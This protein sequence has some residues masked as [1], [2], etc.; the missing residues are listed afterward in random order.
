MSHPPY[1]NSRS[2]LVTGDPIPNEEVMRMC[3]WSPD[4][5]REAQDLG[6]S[7]Q[8]SPTQFEALLFYLKIENAHEITFGDFR[9]WQGHHYRQSK[10]ESLGL[11][12]A[13]FVTLWRR[14]TSIEFQ[15]FKEENSD[16]WILPYQI[17]WYYMRARRAGLGDAES[18][19]AIELGANG[20]KVCIALRRR[21]SHDL[22]WAIIM[23][24]RRSKR[25]WILAE[26]PNEVFKV[27]RRGASI[28]EVL[29]RAENDTMDEIVRKNSP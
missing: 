2:T 13:E 24:W 21:L 20:F 26:N 9:H 5:I 14:L 7:L 28:A 22:A 6:Y 11:S 3:G 1:S 15:I 18:L 4:E 25:P 19:H 17:I 16:E 27:F 12:F 23:A 8:L 29:Q 10:A